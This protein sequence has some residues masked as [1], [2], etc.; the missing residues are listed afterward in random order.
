MVVYLSELV[1]VLM[2]RHLQVGV[3]TIPF[4]YGMLPQTQLSTRLRD[5]R[6]RLGA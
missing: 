4:A 6:I 1:L 3:L 5:I 2:D